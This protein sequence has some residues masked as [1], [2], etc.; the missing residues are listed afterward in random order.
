MGPERYADDVWWTRGH[1]WKFCREQGAQV[2]G[3][4]TRGQMDLENV[5]RFAVEMFLESPV[6]RTEIRTWLEVA[7]GEPPNYAPFNTGDDISKSEQE[8]A[9]HYIRCLWD[10]SLASFEDHLEDLKMYH[11]GMEAS[12]SR[13]QILEKISAKR[14]LA[15]QKQE[16]VRRTA[17]PKE[18]ERPPDPEQFGQNRKE[19]ALEEPTSIHDP[20]DGQEDRGKP[21]HSV[22][23]TPATELTL[24]A[25]TTQPRM[26]AAIETPPSEQSFAMGDSTV[27]PTTDITPEPTRPA[28]YDIWGDD[29]ESLTELSS[30]SDDDD[31]AEDEPSQKKAKLSYGL[32]SEIDMH[33]SA[34]L[35]N[36]CETNSDS[37]PDSERTKPH[38]TLATSAEAEPGRGK[39]NFSYGSESEID[40][41]SN[42][43]DSE[44]LEVPLPDVIVGTRSGR[45]TGAQPSRKKAKL[46][47]ESEFELDPVVFRRRPKTSKLTYAKK[48]RRQSKS[49]KSEPPRA[50]SSS[51]VGELD[52]RS[53]NSRRLKRSRIKP[54]G[55]RSRSS[56]PAFVMQQEETATGSTIPPLELTLSGNCQVLNQPGV[57]EST[58]HASTSLVPSLSPAGKLK[59][60]KRKRKQPAALTPSDPPATND[61]LA[62]IKQTT[63]NNL[64]V[65]SGPSQSAPDLSSL[66]RPVQTPDPNR[67]N[68]AAYAKIA[69]EEMK[70]RKEMSETKE[71]INRS[72]QRCKEKEQMKQAG[73]EDG[74]TVIRVM[75]PSE[76]A[77]EPMS[78]PPEIP[79]TSPSTES[80]R[81]P[82]DHV[83]SLN[84]DYP[85]ISV[86]ASLEPT[87]V[88]PNWLWKSANLGEPEILPGPPAERAGRKKRKRKSE[89]AVTKEQKPKSRKAL[90]P[91]TVASPESIVESTSSTPELAPKNARDQRRAIAD[92]R[93][94]LG[95]SS[96]QGSAQREG[97]ILTISVVPQP[98]DQDP[99]HPSLLAQLSDPISN[100]PELLKSAS[101]L[102]RM[103]DGLHP[104]I[105]EELRPDITFTPDLQGVD[106]QSAQ[107]TRADANDEEFCESR[108]Q[109]VEGTPTG[110]ETPS[111]VDLQDTLA[112]PNSETCKLAAVLDADLSHAN[113]QKLVS[114]TRPLYPIV[115][116]DFPT[117]Q[118]PRPKLPV[119]PQVWCMEVSS[120]ILVFTNQ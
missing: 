13:S 109:I 48:F 22:A 113:V 55:F 30:S 74:R 98:I 43:S 18:F 89:Q 69:L 45:S 111:Q 39:T 108:R 31:G 40:V 82:E 21:E 68:L 54:A 47:S 14:S 117:V 73:A 116:E 103:R 67:E 83:E 80:N 41:S 114:T 95:E 2:R 37:A 52:E 33:S 90:A 15:N 85:P 70:A 72:R 3:R 5:Q 12:L 34:S 112:P 35:M 23:G 49:S 119:E 19:T 56:T 16:S 120:L 115:P 42:T 102:I 27:A 97:N 65:S 78:T 92:A 51:A 57:Q 87:P 58:E 36:V 88:E 10:L 76:I 105:E 6:Q 63:S 17:D 24:D 64:E 118:Y 11:N 110:L 104:V 62:T 9:F 99:A 44:E 7:L 79:T 66:A 8:Y 86:P 106:S 71:R 61:L 60:N 91:E 1:L 77:A 46:G 29:D 84:P 32:E 81:T 4:G 28:Y 25:D 94:V 100:L 53:R 96:R 75:P 93:E 38:S 20:E 101:D 50:T 26:E 59:Q 107:S